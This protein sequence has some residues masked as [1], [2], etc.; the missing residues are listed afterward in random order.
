MKGVFIR[1]FIV[2]YEGYTKKFL[3]AITVTCLLLLWPMGNYIT[4][5]IGVL[6]PIATNLSA[7]NLFQEDKISQWDK[8]LKATNL[9]P[10]EVVAAR[11]LAFLTFITISALISFSFAYASYLIHKD[12]SLILYFVFPIA[13]VLISIFMVCL[14]APVS[15]KYGSQGVTF[16]VL[17]FGFSVAFFNFFAERIDFTKLIA[18]LS[19]LTLQEGIMI[20]VCTLVLLMF[21]SI[22]LSVVSYKKKEY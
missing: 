4:P 9:K 16:V 5:L 19:S 2:A 12:N 1:D 3:I 6:L 13:G 20:I 21:I 18:I 15:Y 22:V 10:I 14:T 17:F 7:F 8:Y 11:Y